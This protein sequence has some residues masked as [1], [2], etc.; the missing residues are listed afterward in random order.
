VSVTEKEILLA[1]KKII[2]SE[3]IVPEMTSASVFAAFGKLKLKGKVVCI[4]TGSGL[5]DVKEFSSNI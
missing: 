5:K 2:S 1:H 3:S 4:N